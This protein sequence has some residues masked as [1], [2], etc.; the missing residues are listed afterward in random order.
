[1]K[2][3]L[4]VIA[5]AAL[6]PVFGPDACAGAK[7]NA[8]ELKYGEIIMPADIHVAAGLEC[9]LWW[10]SV[11]NVDE[12]D[13]SVY[14]E[15][16]LTDMS[17]APVSLGVQFFNMDRCARFI[18][19]ES[20]VGSTYTLRI[21]SRRTADREIIS[22]VSTR[23]HVCSPKA[24][25][26]HRN[27]LMMGDSRTWQSFGGHDYV[28]TAA[29]RCSE[30][31]SYKTITA[32]VRRLVGAGK[33]AEFTFCGHMVSGI[34]PEVRN[35]ADNGQVFGYPG[36]KFAEAGGMKAYMAANGMTEGTLDYA[37]IMYG[38]NDISDWGA[39]R[40][41]QYEASRSKIEGIVSEAK[42]LVDEIVSNY[43]EARII[44]VL[45]PTTCAC[46]DGWALWAGGQTKRTS[47]QEMEKAAKMLRK[48]LIAAFDAGRYSA[49]VTVNAAGLW[50][51][52]KYGFPFYLGKVSSRQND[53]VKEVFIECVHP[54]D[55]GY[56]QIADSIFS[57]IKYLEQ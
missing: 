40:I 49:N 35:C 20:E 55:V 54:S 37:T 44:M 41:G 24:G 27:I 26:G 30:K 14:F 53:T 9:N 12:G 22:D 21:V 11:A 32:E 4:A 45:E 29:E 52:R 16:L 56:G 36:R 46:Q 42:A 1:M 48:E 38:I 3:F 15:T 17:G 23:L 28:S 6:A 50:C 47:M 43:P 34:D 57:T 7:K 31:G 25:S 8:G 13:T 2:K 5:I 18:P 10:S 33:G 51:D 19:A 39:N